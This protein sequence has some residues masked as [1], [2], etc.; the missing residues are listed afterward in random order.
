MALNVKPD[1]GPFSL[2]ADELSRTF[3]IC[4]KTTTAWLAYPVTKLSDKVANWDNKKRAP[5]EL[6]KSVTTPRERANVRLLCKSAEM[7]AILQ[8]VD[9]LVQ[10]PD[11]NALHDKIRIIIEYIQTE[12][13]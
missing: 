8:E 5:M 11:L 7:Y 9:R 3:V 12:Q 6:W 10:N 13:P 1:E 2:C 4:S